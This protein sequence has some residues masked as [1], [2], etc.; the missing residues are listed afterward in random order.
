MSAIMKLEKLWG[1]SGPELCAAGEG[2][3]FVLERRVRDGVLPD[4]MPL[5]YVLR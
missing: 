2:R 5:K 4:I 3:E 1:V